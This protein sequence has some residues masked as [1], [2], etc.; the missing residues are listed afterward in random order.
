VSC[1][2]QDSEWSSIKLRGE[3]LVDSD[4]CSCVTPR[5]IVDVEIEPEQMSSHLHEYC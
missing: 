3:D 2:F 4:I 1:K 5:N